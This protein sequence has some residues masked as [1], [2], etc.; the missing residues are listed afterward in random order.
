MNDLWREYI[1]FRNA[2][3][4]F[5]RK[6]RL[7]Y[8]MNH[9]LDVNDCSAPCRMQCLQFPFR[10]VLSHMRLVMLFVHAVIILLSWSCSL[11]PSPVRPSSHPSIQAR[12][13]Q[14][15]TTPIDA[16][17]EKE[18]TLD[19]H[20]QLPRKPSEMPLDQRKLCCLYLSTIRL[21]SAW[22]GSLA[23]SYPVIRSFVRSFARRVSKAIKPAQTLT[24][25]TRR[26]AS[27][28]RIFRFS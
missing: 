20:I 11:K 26:N 25:A 5:K 13:K 17:E 27:L 22:K 4:A 8:P 2:F 14:Q 12:E 23:R 7:S 10:S 16:F 18:S 15:M 28:V 19:E 24:K 9:S 1:S 3:L 21:T 6:T